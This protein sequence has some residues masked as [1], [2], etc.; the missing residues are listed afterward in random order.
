[1]RTEST[2]S[3]RLREAREADEPR[4]VEIGNAIFPEYRQTLEEFRADRAGL[5]AGGYVSV[6]TVA[7][8]T[9][10]PVVGSSHFQHMPVQYDPARFRVGVYV[11]PAWQRRGVGS[12]LHVRLVED[13]RAHGGRHLEANARET[14]SEAVA[15]LRARDFRQTMR[16]WEARLDVRR[17]DPAPFAAYPARVRAQGIV[18]TTL[19][20]EARHDAGALRRAHALHDAVL[21]AIPSP[22]PATPVPFEE[23]LRV[24]VESPS[25]LPDA[26]FIAKD[27]EAYVGEANLRRPA[28][29]THLY[30]NVTGVLPTHRGRGI[31]IVMKLAT[32][33]YAREHGAAEIRTWN[34]VHNV[35]MLA[36]NDRFGFVRQPAWLTFER[37]V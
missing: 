2:V 28:L 20:E 24:N 30:H 10:G 18:V 14:M 27:G 35:E 25:A 31:A 23:F 19:A 6:R 36:I 8:V 29:G 15:F 32:I 4:I 1:M 37:D 13:V 26:Y 9:G 5:R 22:I 7:E 16:T 11:D 3:I 12:A 17:F 21:A 34:D 33:A